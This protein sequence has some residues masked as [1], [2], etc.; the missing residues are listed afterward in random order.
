MSCH[1]RWKPW[2]PEI[3]VLWEDVGVEDRGGQ[4]YGQVILADLVN[5]LTDRV[6]VL[7]LVGT[8]NAAIN[9]NCPDWNIGDGVATIGVRRIL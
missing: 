8:G 4:R 9:C 6:S 2:V 7:R 1:C 3:P 5:R